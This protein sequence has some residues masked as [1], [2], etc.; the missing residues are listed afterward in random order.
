MV[1]RFG[2]NLLADSVYRRCEKLWGHATSRSWKGIGSVEYQK[3]TVLAI[4]RLC[5]DERNVTTFLGNAG[6]S[7]RVL[8][9]FRFRFFVESFLPMQAARDSSHVKWCLKEYHSK[10]IIW[11]FYIGRLIFIFNTLYIEEPILFHIFNNSNFRHCSIK[12]N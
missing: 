9:L 1:N 10:R 12:R 11:N 8:L 4:H 3:A 6:K 7:G 2:G 5:G